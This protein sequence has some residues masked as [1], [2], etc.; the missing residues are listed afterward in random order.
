MG[1]R[2]LTRAGRALHMFAA[3]AAALAVSLVVCAAAPS[4]SFAAETPALPAETQAPGAR[5]ASGASDGSGGFIQDHYGLFSAGD[6]SALEARA[7]ELSSKGDCGVY[8]LTVDDIDGMNVRDFAKGYYR[9]YGLGLGDSKSGIMFLIAVGSRDYVTITYGRG[10]TL[11]TDYQI[12]KLEDAVLDQISDDQWLDGANAYLD[13]C[14]EAIGFYAENGEPLDSHNA[15]KNM[16]LMVL[17]SLVGGL[18]LAGI[19]A[20]GMTYGPYRAMR[21]ARESTEAFAYVDDE[22]PL[23]IEGGYDR[24]RT[25][26]VVAV[27]LPKN[28]GGS[29]GGGSS[30]DFDGF[31]GSRGGKF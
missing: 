5:L 1:A 10:T 24:F 4:A 27:P 29:R 26:T 31:G 15:P 28:D 13:S 19:I 2:V 6:R 18:V 7:A 3:C 25:T 23:Q 17:V 12:G 21:S 30:I 20:G 9:Q 22:R 14:E 11:F 16:G 8:L